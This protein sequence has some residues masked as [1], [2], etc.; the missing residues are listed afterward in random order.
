MGRGRGG[1]RG[2]SSCSRSW[3]ACS[4]AA[5]RRGWRCRSAALALALAGRPVVA[6]AGGD[7]GE[8]RAL[9]SPTPARRGG[10]RH[11]AGAGRTP[12]SGCAR[13]CSSRCTSAPPG[14]AACGSPLDASA[15]A[16]CAARRRRFSRRSPPPRGTAPPAARPRG[17][18]RA[19]RRAAR[20]ARA[21]R[22]L[23][24]RRGAHAVLEAD[25][26]RAPARSAVASSGR[27]TPCGA[28]AEAALAA[29]L[30]P[31]R[32]RA[33]SA[34]WCSA[35]TS[36]DRRGDRDDFR[37]PGSPTCWRPAARTSCCSRARARA[38]AALGLPAARRGSPRAIALVALYVPLAGRG[39][40]IQRAGVMGAAG[41]VA[42]LA[43]RPASR[44]YA[45]ALAAAVTLALNP[46]AAGDPG[47]QLSSPPSWPA[48]ARAAA[49]RAR[50]VARG[51][52]GAAGRGGRADR[53]GDARRPPRCSPS[54]SSRSRSSR[55]RR[56][57]SPRPRSRRS[58]GSAWSRRRSP[59]S[60]PRCG[61]LNAVNAL[62]LGYLGWVAHVAARR[63]R[64]LPRAARRLVVA[65]A[66]RD[67]AERAARC[68]RA[69]AWP[70]RR[71]AA[72][73]AACAAALGAAAASPRSP[74]APSRA[75]ARRAPAAPPASSRLVPRRRPGRRDAAPARR[76]ARVLVD[77]GPPDGP[78]VARLRD[79]GRRAARRARAHPRAGRPRGR[80]AGG[81][82]RACRSGWSLDGGAGWPTPR[83]QRGAAALRRARP[84][85]RR[86]PDAGQDP[87]RRRA[88]L[89]VLWPPAGAPAAAERRPQRP[90]GRRPL[91]ERR[92]STCC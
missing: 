74:R 82:R 16:R 85:A 70:A 48:R 89:D 50:C 1:I 6:A 7:G 49:A 28:A 77:T 64:P 67:A 32:G 2:T 20:G 35:R 15:V 45:L 88:R 29:G 81:A 43:G 37:A 19:G 86:R 80:G 73:A 78:I 69:R 84:G 63:A 61:P 36:A 12:R 5:G 42:A 66:R 18:R 59:R 52:P 92:R 30:P 62:P 60:R 14:V 39:P 41:L 26:W 9:R 91:R 76:R 13:R 11:A 25:R 17:R 46:R 34:G 53:R 33:R 83:P 31:P 71:V 58:C 38:L 56:T 27:W 65:A 21:L 90:R 44:W 75:A 22:R 4:A 8:R 10:H 68:S 79:A 55:C 3:P 51:V 40:S 24:R 23:Q 57:C 87:A 47:W 54:T 72:A